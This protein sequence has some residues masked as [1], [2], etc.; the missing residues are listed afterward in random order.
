M[1]HADHV[2]D[3]IEQEPA[4]AQPQPDPFLVELMRQIEHRPQAREEVP[5]E[6]SRQDI[7]TRRADP[8]PA[9]APRPGCASAL[10]LSCSLTGCLPF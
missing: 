8:Q 10:L 5:Q 4:P 7:P 6:E 1:S 3:T 2:Q 9:P